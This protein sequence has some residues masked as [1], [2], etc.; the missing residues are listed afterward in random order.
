MGADF[1][2]ELP[3][4]MAIREGA[5]GGRPIVATEPDGPH[6]AAYR[7][8]ADGVWARAAG[9]AVKPAPGIVIQ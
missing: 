7:A 2:G 3:L 6:A 1:L 8:I 5:D 4:D 9:G